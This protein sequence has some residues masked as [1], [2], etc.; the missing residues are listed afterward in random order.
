MTGW[1]GFAA[2]GTMYQKIKKEDMFSC[3]EVELMPTGR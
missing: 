2:L 1:S 3:M